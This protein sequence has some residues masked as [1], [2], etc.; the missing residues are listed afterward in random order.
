[1]AKVAL[2]SVGQNF[3]LQW[4]KPGIAFG[5]WF[6]MC[7]IVTTQLLLLDL[8]RRWN[9]TDQSGD[10]TTLCPSKSRSQSVYLCLC[11]AVIKSSVPISVA[12][13]YQ[14]NL[15]S[16]FE[17]GGEHHHPFPVLKS[18]TKLHFTHKHICSSVVLTFLTNNL[19]GQTAPASFSTRW[20]VFTALPHSENDSDKTTKFRAL[21]F[22]VLRWCSYK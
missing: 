9:C 11:V 19:I 15:A 16:A 5:C 8:K 18:A 14:L 6:A 7:R 2:S 10:Y 21:V 22:Y 17:V 3:T 20:S 1:M 13:T 12:D 4:I